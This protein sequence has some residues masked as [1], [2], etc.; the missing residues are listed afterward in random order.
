[1]VKNKKGQGLSL[2]FLIVAI[3]AVIA[4]VIV[5]LYFT[6][7]LEK[8]FSKQ[9]DISAL[10]TQELA[11]AESVCKT[12]CSVKSQTAYDAPKFSDAVKKAGFSKC[13]DLKNLGTFE[14]DCMS[15]EGKPTSGTKKCS[16]FKKK[17]D[18]NAAGCIWS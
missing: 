18:C 14:E 6:G 8:M 11:L 2:N 13:S 9:K 16:E 12:A 17:S 10:S 4:L 15:C 5:A 1:M 3:L 7:G